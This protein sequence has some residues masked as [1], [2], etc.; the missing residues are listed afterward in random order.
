[1]RKAAVIGVVLLILI[2]WGNAVLHLF[3]EAME[4]VLETLEL[5]TER[6]LEALFAVTPHE[7]QAV[8]AW[9]GLTALIVLL[10]S[11][12]RKL[13][14]WLRLMRIKAPAWWAVQKA[15]V[16]EMRSSI[17][18]SFGILAMVILLV[19]IYF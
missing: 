4:V 15:R 5:I 1:M 3:L 6:V 18:W 9:L 7:A 8:T 11:A 12:Y 14:A 16:W 13:A 17:G 19:L 10:A 2:I